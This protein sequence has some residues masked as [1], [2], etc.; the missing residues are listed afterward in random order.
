M[1]VNMR[2]QA[3]IK[4]MI[5]DDHPIVRDGIVN[6]SLIYDDIE[7]VGKASGGLEL[8]ARLQEIVPDVILMDMVMPGMDGLETTRAV[9]AQHPKVKIVI[10]TSFLQGDVVRDI[11]EAGAVGYFSKHAEIGTLVD[12]IRAAHAG[13]TILSSEAT[14]AL[15]QTNTR[16]Q[17]LGQDLSKRELEVLSLLIEGLSNRE[18]GVRLAISSGTVKHHVSACMSKLDAANR[19]QAAA[20]A[21]ELQL[22]PSSQA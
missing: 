6:L 20:L 3:P 12:A 9:L 4:V 18:I 7:L 2:E 19:A 22:I 5:V 15:L 14:S 21:I 1:K 8:L 11:L 17:E 16:S 13:H 10:L